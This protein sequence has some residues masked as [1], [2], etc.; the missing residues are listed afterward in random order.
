MTPPLYHRIL[1]AGFEALPRRVRELHDLGHRQVWSGQASVERGKSLPCRIAAALSGLPPAG[2]DQPLTVVFEPVGEREVWSRRFGS[3]LFRTVQFACGSFLC[4]RAG[5]ATF[6]FTPIAS[7]DELV[8]R[9]DG[10]RVL[11]LPLPPL[12]HPKVRTSEREQN[13]R[14]CFEVEAS[15]P[16]FGLLVRYAGWLEPSA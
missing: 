13:G 9:L 4:E 10:F 14:Y 16:L 2:P 11:G 12:L 15:L 7:A 5:P 6:V 1:G 3:A 8:L